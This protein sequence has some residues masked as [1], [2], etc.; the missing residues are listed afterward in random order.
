VRY[1]IIYIAVSPCWFSLRLPRGSVCSSSFECELHLLSSDCRETIILLQ[2]ELTTPQ[3]RRPRAAPAH[4]RSVVAI[5]SA[6]SH[7]A[8]HRRVYW[9]GFT[10]RSTGELETSLNTITSGRVKPA[11]SLFGI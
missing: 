9:E 6:R 5:T 11:G 2:N 4:T 10:A 8:A 7:S 1:K 3:L